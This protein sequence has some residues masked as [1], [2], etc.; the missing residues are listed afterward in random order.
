MVL[1]ACTSGGR[2]AVTESNRGTNLSP[3]VPPT[4]V[5]LS[6]AAVRGSLLLGPSAVPRRPS[7]DKALSIAW[8]SAR[9]VRTL[10]CLKRPTPWH[11]PRNEGPHA[12]LFLQFSR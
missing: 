6:P 1:P 3:S 5:S 12:P 2:C 11:T 7:C 9:F 8:L 10:G 4:P